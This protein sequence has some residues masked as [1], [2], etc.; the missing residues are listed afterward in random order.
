MV[1]TFPFVRF[2]VCLRSS[3]P[4]G[5]LGNVS[6]F[7]AAQQIAVPTSSFT[8]TRV[9]DTSFTPMMSMKLI[10]VEAT[11]TWNKAKHG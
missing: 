11:A 9:Q 6:H 2:P 8:T 3:P 7:V 10:P 5:H 4:P 1:V